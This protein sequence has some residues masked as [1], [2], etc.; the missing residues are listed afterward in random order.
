MKPKG[1]VYSPTIKPKPRKNEN[2]YPII[3]R[4]KIMRSANLVITCFKMQ[5]RIESLW[6]TT[7]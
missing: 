4:V 3:L 6:L 7:P 2:I 1:K 5:K